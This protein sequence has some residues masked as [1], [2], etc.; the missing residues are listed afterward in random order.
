MAV[1]IFQ[2][3]NPFAKLIDSDP[4]DDR[5]DKNFRLKPKFRSPPPMKDGKIDFANMPRIRPDRV[6]FKDSAGRLPPDVW[7]HPGLTVS[8]RVREILER[9][10]PDGLD[11]HPVVYHSAKSNRDDQRYWFYCDKVI[12]ALDGEASNMVLQLKSWRPAR[13]FGPGRSTPIEPL[14]DY[15]DPGKPPMTTLKRSMAE[16][17]PIFR[18][19]GLNSGFICYNEDVAKELEDAEVTGIEPYGQEVRWL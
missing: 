15:A 12:D 17:E 5:F 16:Q 13:D 7:S 3:V 11:F 1:Y 8:E 19:A 2:A 14:P 9:Y 10:Q 6:K 4:M 18:V